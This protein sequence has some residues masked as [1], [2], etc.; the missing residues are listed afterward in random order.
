MIVA[1]MRVLAWL[2]RQGTRAVAALVILG[3]ALP[4]FDRLLKPYVAPAIFVLLCV[5]FVRLDTLT[6]VRY[7]RRPALVVA[8]TAWTTVGIPVVVGTSSLLAGFDRWAPDLFQ[9]LILQAVTSPMMAA[10]AFASLMGLDATLVL[11][12]LVASSCLTPVSVPFFTSLF[13]GQGLAV[14]PAILGMTLLTILGG[15]AAIGLGMRRLLGSSA[16]ERF[17]DQIDGFNIL[18]L[19]VFVA[20]VMEDV[21]RSIVDKPAVMAALTLLGFVL[22]GVVF[23][24]TALLFAG[25]GRERALAL[26]FMTSQRNMGLMLAA[27][28]GALP[29]ITWLYFAVCQFPIYFSPQLLKP[30]VSRLVR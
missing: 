5:A 18:I 23:A 6:L 28:G 26:G 22:F 20:A 27:T 13:V 2:G 17:K 12:T 21:A 25:A 7:V 11:V 24:V 4:H 16:I 10:P 15:S 9:G 8:A 19:F 1:L 14:S 29:D 30:I 3:I